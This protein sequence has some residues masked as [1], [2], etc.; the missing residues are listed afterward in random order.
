[1]SYIRV[2]SLGPSEET[3]KLLIKIFFYTTSI[4]FEKA[5]SIRDRLRFECFPAHIGRNQFGF[6]GF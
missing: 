1:M 4:Y 2:R 6:Q 3:A 5:Q